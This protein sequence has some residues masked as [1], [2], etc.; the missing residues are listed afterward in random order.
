MQ[1]SERVPVFILSVA[2]SGMNFLSVYPH[3]PIDLSVSFLYVFCKLPVSS[4]TKSLQN[5][6]TN[7]ENTPISK[8]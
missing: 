5:T 6:T 4:D 1:E 3:L 2:Q 7:Y 8:Y